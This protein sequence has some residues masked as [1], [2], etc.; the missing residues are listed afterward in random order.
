MRSV[1]IATKEI[2]L[3]MKIIQFT[4][5][6]VE[7]SEAIGGQIVQVSFDEDPDQDPF[8]RKKCYIT[9][10]Q[11][12]EFPNGATIE[13]HDGEDYDG[14]AEVQDFELTNSKFELQTSTELMFKVQHNC[15]REVLKK[16]EFFLRR[17]F[18]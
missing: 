15:D 18:K 14:G 9:I 7:Y 8:E 4:A 11:N 10:S 17:E 13:W 6:N 1:G 2:V 3:N 12:Y 16:I 5:S